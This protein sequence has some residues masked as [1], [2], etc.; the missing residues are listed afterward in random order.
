M[1]AVFGHLSINVSDTN[2]YR[3]LLEFL[4]YR[5]VKQAP[6]HVGMSDGQSSL[7]IHRVDSHFQDRGF[8]R[9][10]L[11]INHLAFKVKSADDVDRFYRDF[12]QTHKIPVLYGGPGKRPQYTADY[13]AVYF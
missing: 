4:D 6:N 8:H 1:K 3:E 12:L 11:G 9:K 2:F 5:P 10:G 7:W 13:Y